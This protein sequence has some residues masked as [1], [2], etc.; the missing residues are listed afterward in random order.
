MPEYAYLG[1][2]LADRDAVRPAMDAF[3]AFLAGTRRDAALVLDGVDPTGSVG[4]ALVA[5]L[6]ARGIVPTEYADF[7]RAALRRR[8]EPTYL[9]EALSASGRKK[10]RWS[11]RAIE[12]ELGAAP[13]VRDRAADPAAWE[14]FLALERA[15]WKGEQGTALASAPGDAVFF[16]EMCA[17]TAEAG[18]LQLLSLECGGRVAAMQCNLVDGPERYVFKV[19]YDTELGRFSPGVMLWADATEIFHADPAAQLA[20]SCAAPGNAPIERVW[21]DRRRLQT[22]IVPT[23]APHRGLIRPAVLAEAAA[24]GLRRRLRRRLQNRGTV[25]P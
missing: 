8:P 13:E 14:T 7:E 19:A 3:A 18:R 25:E 16:R 20:D 10:L 23:G 6:A 1:T 12:R 21:P 24:R 9:E 2:P 15:S 5:A 4:A 17:R 22:L 11:R